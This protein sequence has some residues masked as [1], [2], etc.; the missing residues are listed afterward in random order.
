MIESGLLHQEAMIWEKDI[1]WDEHVEE[2]YHLLHAL[3]VI[4]RIHTA[5]YLLANVISDGILLSRCY[6][7]WERRWAVVSAPAVLCLAYNVFGVYYIVNRGEA[8]AADG[9]FSIPFLLVGIISNLSLTIIIATKILL[10]FKRSSIHLGQQSKAVY[11]STLAIVIES[12]VL[13]PIVLVVLLIINICTVSTKNGIPNAYA[14]L[15]AGSMSLIHV[16]G[17]APTLLVVRIGLGSAFQKVT[18]HPENPMQARETPAEDDNSSIVLDIR[19][20]S[21]AESV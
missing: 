2:L 20:G 13:Y 5:C 6:V 4:L 7:I 16:V 21:K 14:P 17:I 15:D 11:A 19:R 3:E 12:G 9:V 10:V 8:L 18:A 1:G